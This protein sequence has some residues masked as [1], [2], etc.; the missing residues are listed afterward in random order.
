M[1][2]QHYW[3]SCSFYTK[4][5][6]PWDGERY[7]CKAGESILDLELFLLADLTGYFLRK[8]IA[9]RNCIQV[10]SATQMWLLMHTLSSEGVKGSLCNKRTCN[11]RLY[12]IVKMKRARV[13][14]EVVFLATCKT[15]C[16]LNKPCLDFLKQSSRKYV[17]ASVELEV[18]RVFSISGW[19]L[20]HLSSEQYLGDGPALWIL[21][22]IH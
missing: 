10:V 15:C 19:V 22:H 8:T 2:F 1:S 3:Q 11:I 12:K 9:Q 21:L 7:L 13:W 16:E 17:E 18:P 6:Y 4:M 20:D 5:I 14:A